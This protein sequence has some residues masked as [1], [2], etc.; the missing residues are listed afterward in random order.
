V[1]LTDRWIGWGG[2]SELK[3]SSS[4]ANLVV[5]KSAWKVLVLSVS[6]V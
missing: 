5:L 6:L 2:D 3:A 4:A 1:V